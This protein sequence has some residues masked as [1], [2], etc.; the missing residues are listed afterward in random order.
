MADK[1]YCYVE[2]INIPLAFLVW[3]KQTYDHFSDMSPESYNDIREVVNTSVPSTP[4]TF[5]IN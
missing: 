1:T 4:N 5:N 2:H 3:L